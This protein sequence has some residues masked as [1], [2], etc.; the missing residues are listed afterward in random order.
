[1]KKELEWESSNV[2]I[3][4]TLIK[5]QNQKNGW[6]LLTLMQK[7][8]AILPNPRASFTVKSSR[9][10]GG[11]GQNACLC[12]R[13]GREE[14]GEDGASFFYCDVITVGSCLESTVIAQHHCLF[15]ATTG[16]D[17]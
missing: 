11:S 1:M 15:L 7:D 10:N 3:K 14:E 8:Q 6:L 13:D 17:K 16:S 4:T 5:Q 12:A 2:A 9:N